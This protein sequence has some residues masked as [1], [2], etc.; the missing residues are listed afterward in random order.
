[1][2]KQFLFLALFTCSSVFAQETVYQAFEVDSAAQ[3]HGGMGYLTAFLQNNLR[4]PVT[5]ESKGTGGRIVVSGIVEADGQVTDVKAV[6]T[7]FPDLNREAVRVFSRFSAWQPAQ[8]GGKAVRQQVMIPVIFGP[9]PPFTYADGARISYYDADRKPVAEGSDQARYRQVAPTDTNGLPTGNTMVY[10]AKGADWQADYMIPFV[11]KKSDQRSPWGTSIFLIG[12]QNSD[13]QWEGTVFG[14]DGTGVLISRIEYDNGRSTGSEITYHANGLIAERSTDVDGKKNMTSWY[15]N[16][17]IRQIESVNTGK[18]MMAKKTAQSVS[19]PDLVTAFWDSTGH[20]LV[21]EGNGRAVYAQMRRSRIDTTRQ[22]QYVEQGMFANGFKQGVWTGRYADR[23]Y[24][25]EE[26][27]DRGVCKGGKA[28]TVGSDMVRYVTQ[29]QQPEFRG[30]MNGLGQFLSQNLRYPAD[31]QRAGVQGKVYI[32]FVVCTDGT[33]CDY[34]IMKGVDPSVDQEA[35]RVVKA[36]SGRWKPG[37]ERG[38][39]VRV[40]YNMPINFTLQ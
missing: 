24:F 30:G 17:Q 16:G 14:V 40:K 4:K 28:Q 11:R 27:Y 21:R 2:K 26:Q 34:E 38:Q 12:Y 19:D 25:Y 36:M 6:Q 29:R 20:Q 18:P 1:M 35:L 8:K 5:A 23:S 39:N 37:A 31:A 7:K 10:K 33:L 13:N 22:T 9:N 32:S 15:A 3:P